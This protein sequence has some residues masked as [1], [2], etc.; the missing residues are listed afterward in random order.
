M[1]NEITQEVQDVLTAN[2]EEITFEQVLAEDTSPLNLPV[3][4]KDIGGEGVEDSSENKSWNVW[5]PEGSSKSVEDLHEKQ[6]EVQ[7]DFRTS[8]EAQIAQEKSQQPLDAPEQKIDSSSE[9]TTINELPEQTFQIPIA[10]ANQ[11]ADALLGMTNN[12]LEVG[13]GYFVKLKKHEEFYDFNEIIKLVDEQ[14][15]KNVQRIKLDKEDQ[16]LLRPLL[17]QVLQKKSKK[18]TPEQQLMGA[19]VSILMKKA[20][21]VMEVRAENSLL[22]ARILQIIKEEKKD[23]EITHVNNEDIDNSSIVNSSE[24][25]DTQHVFEEDK[26]AESSILE[27]AETIKTAS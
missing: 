11:A 16:A 27:V 7:A 14:N 24:Q 9:D 22:E 13:G 15:T 20:Q 23:T 3:V 4:E 26:D 18:L 21:T 12:M 19:I 8:T 2:S 5:K 1:K 10:Q 6:S 17:A 25:A